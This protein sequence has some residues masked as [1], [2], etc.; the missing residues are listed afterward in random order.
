MQQYKLLQ[1]HSL[2]DIPVNMVTKFEEELIKFVEENFPHILSSIRDT[3]DL[4]DETEKNIV[5][6]INEFKKL[7]ATLKARW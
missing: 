2:L 5:L 6:A 1:V 3:K 7:F 4:S